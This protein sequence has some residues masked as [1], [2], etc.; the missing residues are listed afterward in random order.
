MYKASILFA[1][2]CLL[3]L[4]DCKKKN[5]CSANADL[6]DSIVYTKLIPDTTVSSVRN[7][8]GWMEW[9]PEKDSSASIFLDVDHNGTMDIQIFAYVYYHFISASSPQA[10]Y[11]FGLSFGMVRDQDD[12]AVSQPCDHCGNS[13]VCAFKEGSAISDN[14]RYFKGGIVYNSGAPEYDFCY[15]NALS[16]DTVGTYYGFRIYDGGCYK[17]G[18]ILLYGGGSA[19][20]VEAYAINETKG[21]SILAGQK[22]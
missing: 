1:T 13:P 14:Y 2:I 6:P 5:K 21:K 10:N 11:D 3:V 22:K 9:P 12:V 17:Y 15:C 7:N 18:W 8:L 4:C 16:S 19:L 20:T